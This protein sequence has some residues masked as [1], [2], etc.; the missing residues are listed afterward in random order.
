MLLLLYVFDGPGEG[1]GGERGLL[2]GEWLY[3]QPGSAT[4]LALKQ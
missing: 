3:R 4:A 1:G 2:F